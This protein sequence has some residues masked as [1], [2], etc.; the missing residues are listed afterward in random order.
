MGST[1]HCSR[2]H[3]RDKVTCDVRTAQK[4]SVSQHMLEG[5]QLF[6]YSVVVMVVIQYIKQV[7]RVIWHKTALL[8][9]ADG[10]V[11]FA[12]WRQCAFPCGHIGTT[13]RIR[14]NLCFLWPTWVCNPN[15]S[16][17]CTALG[18]KSLYLRWALIPPKLPLAMGDLDPH[19]R[20]GS[21]AH[22]SP[23]P[24]RHLDRFSHFCRAH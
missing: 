20:H 5:L 7:V 3:E 22:R 9:Q 4:L 10:S 17:S 14:L 24:K 18:R 19:L 21:L 8:S 12:R 16:R 1:V 23:R 13:W 2:L 6:N 15:G 11:V